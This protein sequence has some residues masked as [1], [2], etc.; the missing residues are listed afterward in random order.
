MGYLLTEA[1]QAMDVQ[2]A[3]KILIFSNNFYIEEVGSSPTQPKA[4]EYV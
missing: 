2:S 1:H 4:R 3:L